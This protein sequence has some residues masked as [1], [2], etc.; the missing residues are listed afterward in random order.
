MAKKTLQEILD[1]HVPATHTV[2]AQTGTTYTF[3]LT[4]AYEAGCALV[5]LSN[6]SAITATVPKNSVVAFPVGCCINC[7]Q[8]GAGQVT[9][10]PVDG[11]VTINPA[12]T[13]KISEQWKGATLIKTATNVW[14][15]IGALT[16]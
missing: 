4:D 16:S 7:Q 2:N 9:F 5:T 10:A 11:D 1:D 15:L 8:I 14:S 12:A 13:L 3:A 6:G